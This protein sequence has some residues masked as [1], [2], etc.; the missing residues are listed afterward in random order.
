MQLSH[1]KKKKK[2][3]KLWN[4]IEHSEDKSLVEAI[5]E[6]NMDN[7]NCCRMRTGE[8]KV[9]PHITGLSPQLT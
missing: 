3:R 1:L 4:R 2:Y 7:E 9:L 8:Q 6:E 5:V